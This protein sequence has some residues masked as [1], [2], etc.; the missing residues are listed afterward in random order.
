MSQDE[1]AGVNIRQFDLDAKGLG[2][3]VGEL[4]ARILEA[5]WAE[6]PTTVKDVAGL[7]GDEHHPKTV[8]TVMNRMVDKGLLLRERQGRAYSYRTT[9]DREAFMASVARQVLDGLLADFG[10]PTLAHFI[11]AADSDQLAELETLIR[12]RQHG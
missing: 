12:R 3:V 5:V 7:L 2:R 10:R 4:Q 9:A 8:M 11:E 6:E 1:R